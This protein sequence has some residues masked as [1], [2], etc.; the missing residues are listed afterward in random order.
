MT[1][2]SPAAR[3]RRYGINLALFLARTNASNHRATTGDL[4]SQRETNLLWLNDMLEHLKSCQQQL[5]WTEDNE[6][7]GVLTETMLRDLDCC[8]RLCESL[9]R[10]VRHQYVS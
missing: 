5:Q 9:K 1:W 6:T 10:Q 2:S 3:A 7:V 8:R 4:M